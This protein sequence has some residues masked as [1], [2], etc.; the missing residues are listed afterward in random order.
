MTNRNFPLDPECSEAQAYVERLNAE[1]GL[2]QEKIERLTP[3][4]RYQ[5]RKCFVYGTERGVFRG[6]G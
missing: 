5:C 4:H 3:I 6:T 1:E 2:T